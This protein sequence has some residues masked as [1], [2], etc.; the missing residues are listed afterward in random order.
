MVPQQDQQGHQEVQHGL[1]HA[2]G[3]GVPR[4]AQ[5]QAAHA[6]K[7]ESE[8]CRRAIV[9]QSGQCRRAM[10]NRSLEDQRSGHEDR[11]Y[12]I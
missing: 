3:A 2:R 7:A 9:N 6:G 4:A 11:R 8:R 5:S 12:P 1:P 10:V